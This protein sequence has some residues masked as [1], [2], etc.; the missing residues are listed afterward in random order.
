MDTI[1]DTKKSIL[2]EIKGLNSNGNRIFVKRD[3]LIHEDVS[4]NKWRKLKYNILQAKAN[5]KSGILT[6]GGAFS[7]HLLATA[8]ACNL[9]NL[10]SIGIIRG[11]EL[12]ENSNHTLKKCHTLGM[13]LIFVSRENYHQKSDYDYLNSLKNEF[14]DFYIVPEGGSN[15]YGMIGCQEITKEIK[16]DFDHLFISQGT[17]TTSCG[18]LLSLKENQTLHVIPALKGFDSLEEMRK[19]LNQALFDSETVEELLKKVQVHPEFHFGGYGKINEELIDFMSK[20]RSDFELH[21]DQVYTAK[22]FY[23]TLQ[24]IEN[25]KFQNQKIVFIHTGGLQGNTHS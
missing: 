11:D 23:G 10:K 5:Q 1:F 16:Q 4:G 9:L 14:P 6:F 17:T 13:K 15:Y 24:I 7:N 18:I 21:L 20:M 25:E 22:A 2:Q 19:I 8:S 12:N 3:D